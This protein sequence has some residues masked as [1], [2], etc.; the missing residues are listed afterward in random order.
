MSAV[1][2]LEIPAA[3]PPDRGPVSN[4]AQLLGEGIP[5]LRAYFQQV[6][7]SVQASYC[8]ALQRLDQGTRFRNDEW[9]RSDE[10][11]IKKGRGLT[12]VLHDG[13]VFEQA[14][15]ALSSV[16]GVLPASMSQKLVGVSEET[17]FSA[18]GVSLIVHPRSPMIP[19]T[20]AN[21]RLLT[22]GAK[23]W[24]G[25]GADLTPYYLFEED[26]RHFH[27]TLRSICNSV[28]PDWYQTFKRW[29]DSYFSL[30]HR[31]ESRGIGGIFYDYLGR[32][33]LEEMLQGAA[34]SERL[35]TGLASCYM[36]IVEQ[37]GD[38]PWGEKE[39]LFQEIRRGRY[40]EFNL[41]Y[42]RGTQFGLQT[43]GRVES[44]LASLPPRVRWSYDYQPE[45][46]SPEALLIEALRSPREWVS[47]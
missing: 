10:Q 20:H 25:G 13:A 14:V 47:E 21:I 24:F 8:D 6:F 7:Q 40:V 11:V 16:S 18:D 22:V 28:R 19:T 31:G 5:R 38:T 32:D 26:A 42:D 35:G 41:L 37:R 39:R 45:P 2:S 9:T 12:R 44:I 3:A 43:G 23:S 1:S 15:V 27:R 36:P 29:C 33:S 17:P 4:Y 34:L 30:P 46:G